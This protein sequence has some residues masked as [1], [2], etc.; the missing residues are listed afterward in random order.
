MIHKDCKDKQDDAI[1]ITPRIVDVK[2]VYMTVCWY[3]F[4]KFTVQQKNCH[5]YLSMEIKTK[6]KS[7]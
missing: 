2:T 7:S 1:Y 3:N 5:Y 4:V 6:T